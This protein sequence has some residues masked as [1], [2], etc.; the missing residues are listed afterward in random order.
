[1]KQLA[2]RLARLLKLNNPIRTILRRIYLSLT[3]KSRQIDP[4]LALAILD[5]VKKVLDDLNIVWWLE[6][7]TCLG[8]VR[9]KGFIEHDKDID[10]GIFEKDIIKIPQIIEGLHAVGFEYITSMK[11]PGNGPVITT[12]RNDIQID[13]FFFYEDND[14]MWHTVYCFDQNKNPFPV[15]HV[16][17]KRWFD[18]LKS[19]NFLGRQ[20]LIPNPPEEYL[21][22]RYGDWRIPRKG[23]DWRSDSRATINSPYRKYHD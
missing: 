6:S 21:K 20:V 13:L 5:D 8:A 12:T 23:W 7:G 11:M 2:I 3:V 14:K 18:E 17:E 10:L 22:H 16:L 1:M 15:K 9:E 19:I 4:I